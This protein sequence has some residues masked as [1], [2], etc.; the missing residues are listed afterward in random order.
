MNVYRLYRKQRLPIGSVQAWAFFAT[1]R[2]LERITPEY[3][4]FH[5][6]SPVP[7]VLYSGLVITYRIRAIA[8]IPMTWVTEI[9]FVEPERRF[10]DEQRIGPFAFWHHEHCFREVDEVLEMEDIVHYAMPFGWLG[11]VVHALLV[12]P[13]LQHI[14]DYRYAC[15]EAMFA[16]QR[17]GTQQSP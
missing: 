6:T 11:R 13:R 7:E 4:H 5:I 8:N 3:L 2:N 16:S 17:E 10:I 1:P 9:K 15:L 14:F 12:G